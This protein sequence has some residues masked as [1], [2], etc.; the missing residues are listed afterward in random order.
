MIHLKP[1]RLQVTIY[2]GG[3]GGE[4]VCHWLNQQA[5]CLPLDIQLLP[6]NR[7]VVRIPVP[8]KSFNTVPSTP[9]KIDSRGV[10]KTF[11]YP[12]HLD[13]IGTALIS[14]I[15]NGTASAMVL[16]NLTGDKYIGYYLFLFLIKTHY[17]KFSIS[18]HGYGR[19]P[20]I[21]NFIDTNKDQLIQQ[22]GRPFYYP[23]EIE[24]I[25]SQRPLLS[26][27]AEIERCFA[28]TVSTHK[29]QFVGKYSSAIRVDT[30]ALYF[31]DT[32]AEYRKICQ[33]ANIQ[34]TQ[35]C[36]AIKDYVQKNIQLVET[37]SGLTFDAFLN[38]DTKSLKYMLCQMVEKHHNQ[39]WPEQY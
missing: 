5:D 35:S 28:H 30:Q 26:F 1:R 7:Y 3:H 38:L 24:N 8:T 34:P 23:H 9:F 18:E 32:K 6:N 13:N 20:H 31:G 36:Q 14:K 16:D 22:L 27:R 21:R 25:M 12:R 4:F 10:D 11:F 15:H 17:Y 37:Y 33:H 39:P 29:T 19:S 2:S